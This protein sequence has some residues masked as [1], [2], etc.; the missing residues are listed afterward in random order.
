MRCRGH[1]GCHLHEFKRT[2]VNKRAVCKEALLRYWRGH[3]DAWRESGLSAQGYA[4]RHGLYKNSIRYWHKKFS[5]HSASSPV[6]SDLSSV[7]ALKTSPVPS[8]VSQSSE[9][10]FVPVTLSSKSSDKSQEP[11]VLRVGSRFRI[12]VPDQFS[13]TTLARLLR[14]LEVFL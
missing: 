10:K 2:I 9:V 8:A 6:I 5:L 11:L 7:S 13:Q 14:T 4:R 1:H 3:V 12:D